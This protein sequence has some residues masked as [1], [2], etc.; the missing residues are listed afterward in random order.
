M[1]IT[2][3][4]YGVQTQCAKNLREPLCASR[5]RK[6]GAAAQQGS[7]NIVMRSAEFI[8]GH[9][10]YKEFELSAFFNP[11]ASYIEQLRAV[12]Q[13]IRHKNFNPDQRRVA[14]RK[15]AAKLQP[16]INEHLLSELEVGGSRTVNYSKENPPP[17]ERLFAQFIKVLYTAK[18]DRIQD[19]VDRMNKEWHRLY[20]KV[21][22][23]EK[24]RSISMNNSFSRAVWSDAVGKWAQRSQR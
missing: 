4:I 8:S 13:F 14:V 23:L 17:D 10:L 2:A 22:T 5:I 24:L 1:V 21:L 9:E 18:D 15:L 6:V 12:A 7:I 20:G 3:D 16:N 19:V 11:H